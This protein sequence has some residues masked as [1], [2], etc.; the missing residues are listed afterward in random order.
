[1]GDWATSP[2]KFD[3]CVVFREA[4]EAARARLAQAIRS[5]IN[6]LPLE[7]RLRRRL[8]FLHDSLETVLDALEP[9]EIS[10][11]TTF[12]EDEDSDA[13]DIIS[14]GEGPRDD[15]D[16]VALT[17]AEL[18]SEHP[19]RTTSFVLRRLVQGPP[20]IT[21]DAR[22][23]SVELWEDR[24]EVNLLEVRAPSAPSFSG[25]ASPRPGSGQWRKESRRFGHGWG[26]LP[27]LTDDLGTR[28]RSGGWSSTGT[29]GVQRIRTTFTPAVPETASQLEIS[30]GRRR[31]R[32]PL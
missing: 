13:D 28:Y 24:V 29:N 30:F 10:R 14:F 31:F 23:V 17:E 1:M 2:G 25:L 3:H 19:P 11:F 22:V 5:E 20:E 26:E 6:A 4:E 15:F 27:A 16:E 18:L 9:Y 12:V 32:V 7:S 8:R 21:E